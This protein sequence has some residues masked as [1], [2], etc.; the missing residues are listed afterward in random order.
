MGGKRRSGDT[1]KIASGV[2]VRKWPSG[3]TTLRISFYYKGV[4]CFETLKIEATAAN[5]KYAERLRGEILNAIERGNFSYPDYF[6]NSKRAHIF[7]HVQS[8]ITIGELLREFLAE[9][10]STKEASTYRGYKRV[11]EGHLLPM[12]DKVE[13]QDLQPAMLR[14]WIRGLQCTTKTVANIL[15]P[16]RAVIEQAL[17][18]QYIKEN[19]LNS[20]IVDK[21]LNKETKKSDYKPDPFSVDEIKAILNESEG[22]VRLLFQF[23]FFT[24]LRVSELIGL[25]WED[26]DWQ[27]QIIHVEE[28]VVAKE[29]KGPKTEAGVR[30]VLLLPPAQEA[31]E[32]QKQYTFSL[33]GRVFHNPQ[34]NKPWETSQQIR[35][36][37]WMHILKRAG[38]R[39]RNTYQTRH[40]YASMMLSQGENIMWV[41]KQLGHVD[42]EM[43]IKT[44][45]RWIP[46]SSSQSGYR[47]VHDWGGHLDPRS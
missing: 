28:T 6:P 1:P 29:A 37:Q 47:P 10:K 24:G 44:Y 4:R 45:G 40:T 9:A 12:F 38:I 7:G 20:I 5:I 36:T 3:K 14:K 23:A 30:D 46:D 32:Q 15:T 25:R 35:R 22:Q 16:L 31:L 26:V 21:L 11:C 34:T 2:I 19:P 33:K 18:D 8:K 17:V 41:S 13:I 27:N 39:Y 43:V 42:V